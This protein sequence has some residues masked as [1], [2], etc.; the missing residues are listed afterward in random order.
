VGLFSV[1]GKPDIIML[2]SIS[3]TWQNW[4]SAS[5]AVD[6]NACDNIIIWNSKVFIWG[7]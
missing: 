4:V 6:V 1:A 7:M 2:T 3:V 5:D